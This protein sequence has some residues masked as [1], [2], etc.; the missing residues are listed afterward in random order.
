MWFAKLNNCFYIATVMK[1]GQHFKY[2]VE[3][4]DFVIF[5][6]NYVGY[7]KLSMQRKFIC[8]ALFIISKHCSRAVVQLT[9]TALK[10]H[11]HA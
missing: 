7:I 4:T 3:N 9:L 6:T 10:I 1:P 2:Y 5:F 11:V 8:I